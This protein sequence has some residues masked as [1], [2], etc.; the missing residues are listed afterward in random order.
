M[1]Y[2][3]IREKII[4]GISLYSGENQL[5]YMYISIFRR[6]SVVAYLYMQEK[7]IIVNSHSYNNVI[8]SSNHM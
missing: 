1:V 6:K 4:C 3:Y 7:I 8:F 5:W 2:L